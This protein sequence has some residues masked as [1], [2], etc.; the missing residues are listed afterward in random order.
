VKLQITGLDV[1]DYISISS[2]VD[3]YFR[4][5]GVYTDV[6]QVSSYVREFI[7]RCMV[8]GRTMIRRNEKKHII[9]CRISNFD[10]VSLYPSAQSRLGGYLKGKPRVLQSLDYE[11][12]KSYDGYFVEIKIIHVGKGKARDF[13]LMSRITDEGIRDF[14]NDMAGETIYVDKFTLEDLIEYHDITFHIVRGYYYNEG[15][16]NV[17]KTTI[18]HLFNERLSAKPRGNP[19]QAV[20]RSGW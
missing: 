17:L 4:K 9:D 16:N 1:D 3:S 14:N 2:L 20:V 5:E 18:E 8:G 7:Q 12:L 19:I 13:P 15:R 11:T 6:Y 10:A